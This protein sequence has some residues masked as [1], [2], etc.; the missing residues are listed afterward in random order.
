MC[1]C[2]AGCPIIQDDYIL[3][4]DYSSLSDLLKCPRKYENA[5]VLGRVP[6]GDDSATAF[7]DLFHRCESLRIEHGLTAAVVQRQQDL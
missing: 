6:I 3:E 5:Y 7:G 4:F 1:P 2:F